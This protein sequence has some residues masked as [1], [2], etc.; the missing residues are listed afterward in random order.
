[1][2]KQ[3]E[4]NRKLHEIHFSRNK[5]NWLFH[6][7][8]I[9]LST[10]FQRAKIFNENYWWFA[11][12][13]IGLG[14][15]LRNL[16]IRVFYDR[17]KTGDKAAAAL[18]YLGMFT[19]A[20]G[21]SC[22]FYAVF[23]VFGPDSY[24]TS[25]TLLNIAVILMGAALSSAAHK[26]SFQFLALPTLLSI[27][28][29]YLFAS[30]SSDEAIM[31]YLIT[32]YSFSFYFITIGNRELIRSVENEIAI[33]Q[34]K[35]RMERIIDTVPGFVSIYDKNLICI[36]AN[37]IM[38]S[39]YP[40]IV[41]RKIGGLETG[42]DWE[43][44]IVKFH[45]SEKTMSV[46]ECASFVEG[47]DRW[48]IR[49]C[50]RNVDNGVVF[51]STEI[52]ELVQAR[53]KLREQEAK[54][55]FS[56]KLASLGEMA[57]G[58][59]H[60]I[61]NPLAIIQGSASVMQKLVDIEPLD[62]DSLKLLTSKMIETTNRISKT[63]KSLKSLSRS[64]DN[65][66]FEKVDLAGLIDQCVDISRQR[67]ERHEIKLTLPTFTFPVLFMAREVQISQVLMNL[68]SNAIDA[69][70]ESENPWITVGY[71]VDENFL[72]ILVSDSGPG[73]PPEIRNKIMEPF[74]T[75]KEVNQGTGL[76]LSISKSILQAHRGEL[77]LV[78]GPH[79]TFRIHLPVN[80]SHGG[81]PS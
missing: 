4:V 76:G 39:M 70:R 1:M 7:M 17:W 73:I 63:I 74:F 22:H 9:I 67:I 72:D 59:A 13:L 44:Y 26:K 58:I 23:R 3:S 34:D 11:F 2:F 51:V 43:S 24:N 66:P 45:E 68:F 18:N 75:T 48:T 54:A 79:T 35:N 55:H 29:L 5:H 20:M 81:S 50:R 77:S 42:S 14:V 6:V 46:D 62:R 57:A 65:D 21:W 8:L 80:G 36:V 32:F 52:T 64:G 78:E 28:F 49:N 40:T 61:N 41:G 31:T 15:V 37:K 47:R 16:F 19:L 56:A 60:E 33:E 53:K 27:F 12:V 25:Q 30:D 69:C 38:L 71:Q 10:Y